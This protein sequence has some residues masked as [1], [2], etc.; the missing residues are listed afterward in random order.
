MSAEWAETARVSSLA[1]YL[2]SF[3]LSLLDHRRVIYE[4]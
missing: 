2:G 1:Q 4:C 3:Y